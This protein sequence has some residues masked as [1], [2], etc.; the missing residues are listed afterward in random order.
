MAK[1]NVLS[2]KI[3]NRI[4][5]GEVV[6]R[7]A[8]VVKELIE[9]SIDAGA[10][11]V[12]IEIYDGGVS[13]IV[14]SDNGCGIE[15]S[16]LKKALLPHA[17]SKI[18]SLSD[19]DNIK[20]LGFRGEALSSIA[21]VS[22]ISILSKTANVELG[23]K[24]SAN[25]GIVDSIIDIG[26]ETGT[27]VTVSN[28]FYN[29][30]AR[31]KFL[32]STR[33]EQSEVS[34][35]ILRFILCN[36]NVAVNYSADGQT[37]YQSFG[38]GLESSMVCVYG[39]KIID[40][41]Y[42]IDVE[43]NG[44]K[45]NGYIGKHH[46]TKPNRTYQSLFLNGRYVINQ[47][48]SSSIMNAYSSYLMRRQYPFYVLNVTMPFEF[49][50]VN[51]HPNKLDVRFVDNQIVYS[52]LYS[53]I[54]KVLD[55]SIEAVSIIANNHNV[56]SENSVDYVTHNSAINDE[57]STSKPLKKEPYDFSKLVLSDILPVDEK[58]TTSNDVF[59][60]NKKYLLELEK[61][62]NV[63]NSS[64]NV[65]N[66]TPDVV[67]SKIDIARSLSYVGQVL[68]TYLILDDGQDMYIV[69]QHAAH[70]RVNYDKFMERVRSNT[71][72]V[73]P[74]LLPYLISVNDVEK[75]F[76]L[77][78]LDVLV[79]MGIDIVEF[80]SREFRVS[81]IPAI[82]SEINLKT[83]FDDLLSSIMTLKNITINDLLKEKIAQKACK[84]SVKA[85]D[86]MSKNDTDI[87]LKMLN[88]NLGLKC[89]HGRPICV[90]I[91]RNEIEKWFKRIV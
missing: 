27:I 51:V 60:E 38:D 80:G 65:S 17:T 26:A 67:V 91:A 63:V 4:A 58:D 89:P 19:L 8:S 59:N 56:T 72:E 44:I 7:P 45:I 25:G 90:K 36:P 43:K 88:G 12:T 35:V 68:N 1:I 79:E 48:I 74:L 33:S 31:E 78:K 14:V 76:L 75:E 53:V 71:I 18:S 32:K 13:K 2:S 40:D 54:S 16:D 21:S 30:P 22:K 50:D 62:K 47:T 77:D 11:K 41:C 52:T 42:Y 70:E 37:I 23:A 9:N 55:G 57:V 28:L 3:F 86:V 49:V 83:F 20:S 85:G 6:E 66:N 61:N 10:T 87:L 84:A 34:N 69:D 73:Q 5:A 81:S 46:F 15:K 29:T 64:I 24:I 82:I 39:T